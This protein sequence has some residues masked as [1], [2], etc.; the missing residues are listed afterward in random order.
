MVIQLGKISLLMQMSS[1]FIL[2]TF[3]SPESSLNSLTIQFQVL[4][5]I[6]VSLEPANKRRTQLECFSVAISKSMP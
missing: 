6:I 4:D 1:K 2:K 3:Y 5:M